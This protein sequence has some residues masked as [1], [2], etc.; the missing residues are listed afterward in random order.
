MQSVIAG[1]QVT[2]TTLDLVYQFQ[3]S[4]NNGYLGANCISVALGANEL[5]LKP[6]IQV[7]SIIA[8]KVGRLTIIE[9]QDIYVAIIII[10]AKGCSSRDRWFQEIRSV[11]FGLVDKLT[12][13]I[14]KQQFAL[15]V[16]DSFLVERNIVQESAIGNEEILEA[17]VVKIKEFRT[18]A[19]VIKRRLQPGPSPESSLRRF[20]PLCCDKGCGFRIPDLSQ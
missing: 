12:V 3:V 11:L 1:R 8:K 2:S 5:H 15:R 14:P 16:G 9:N 19:R 13:Q 4:G 7:T 6:M 10:I 17:V 20:R 18:P